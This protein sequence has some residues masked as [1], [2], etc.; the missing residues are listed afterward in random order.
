[1]ARSNRCVRELRAIIACRICSRATTHAPIDALLQAMRIEA[2]L[3]AKDAEY[4]DYDDDSKRTLVARA[5]VT[6]R[7]ADE[8]EAALRA[9]GPRRTTE[10]NEIDH[11]W[12]AIERGWDIEPRAYF[13]QEAVAMGFKSPVEMAV[14]W[15]W[16]RHAKVWPNDELK[17]VAEAAAVAPSRHPNRS[18]CTP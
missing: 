15:M 3:S 10:A 13:E 18:K 4:Y 16:K 7:W 2:Q 11:F 6:T 8:L 17:A 12:T 9:A 14:H 5:T 1:M